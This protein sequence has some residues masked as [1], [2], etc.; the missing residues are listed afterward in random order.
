MRV[1]HVF[2]GF[3]DYVRE[4]VNSEAENA[5]VHV[6][7]PGGQD[8]S[9]IGLYSTVRVHSSPLGRA[10]DPLNVFRL[11][12]LRALIQDIDP[13]LLHMQSGLMWENAILTR[14]RRY[15]VVVTVHDVVSHPRLVGALSAPQFGTTLAVRSADALITHGES[16]RQLLLN[17]HGSHIQAS[18]VHSLDH[19]VILRYGKG[20]SRPT[21]PAGNGNILFFGFL[22]KYKGLEFLIDAEAILRSSL[23]GMSMV[24]AG[25]T[26]R[27][28]Y[29]RA[30]VGGASHVSLRLGYQ[31]RDSVERL[32]RWAD[33]VVLPYIEASQS[34]VLQ[35]AVAFG[36]P[37][38][39]TT[40][41]GFPDVI[42]DRVNGLLVA[43]RDARS[44]AAA[45]HEL[46]TDSGLRVEII[47]NL[48][49]DRENRFSWARI[50]SQTLQIYGDVISGF[51]FQARSK[52]YENEN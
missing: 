48:Q 50:S 41:G 52:T 19:G 17:K 43:P 35:L 25:A 37:P 6:L 5:D 23:P 30:L 51:H 31:D 38:V 33:I 18:Q 42:R 15:P 34:G 7:I 20:A 10:R 9:S 47:K 4:L 14:T 39:A 8:V 40:V 24:V 36:V 29:Y 11:Q 3:H 26:A 27:P 32:F 49:S 21:V 28:A 13:D 16:S 46:L 12:A 44:L 2:R 45:I 22:D 1:L